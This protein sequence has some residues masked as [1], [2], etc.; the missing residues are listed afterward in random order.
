MALRPAVLLVHSWGIAEEVVVVV[1]GDGVN[2]DTRPV[3]HTKWQR[4]S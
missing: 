4:G 3:M 2:A 1:L